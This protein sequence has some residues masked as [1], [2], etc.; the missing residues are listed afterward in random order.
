MADVRVDVE[1][2]TGP[3]EKD[4]ESLKGKLGKTF[5][6]MGKIAGGIFMA[7]VG[8]QI[9]SKGV[10]TLKT[11]IGLARDY[12]E[13]ISKSNTIFG[14]Q[15]SAVEQWA[16]SAATSFGQSKAE[17]L[18]AAASFG[19]M[20]T[21]LGM[22]S[23]TAKDMSIKMTELAS[24]FASF[25]NADITDVLQAQQAA[26]RGEYDALQKFVP[27][28]NAASVAQEAM[29][30]TGKKNTAELTAGEKAAAAYSLMIKG[31]GDATGDFERTSGS[32]ANQQR[33]MSAQWKDIQA[34][35][36]QALIPA[37]TALAVAINTQVI[38]AV[39]KFAQDFKRYYESDIKPA[40]ENIIAGWQKI[41]PVVLPILETMIKDFARV[42][43][44]F[45]LMVK[46]IVDLI[47]GDWNGAWNDVKQI[48]Q[49]AIDSLTEKLSILRSIGE[50]AFRGFQEGAAD[51]WAGIYGWIKGLP[52]QILTAIGDVTRLLW[53]KGMQI[54]QSLIDGMWSLKGK[55]PNPLDW[56]PGAGAI[57]GAIGD[58]GGF[59]RGVFD[60][61]GGGGGGGGSGASSGLAWDAQRQAYVQPWAVGSLGTANQANIN[62]YYGFG[63][64]PANPA[65]Q[66]II[67][68]IDGKEV[69][70]A[71]N[72]ANARAGV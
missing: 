66:P 36:G 17:A 70:R 45:A 51:V 14:E 21:Q 1:L 55:I 16:S 8:S 12:N 49:N 25:H 58:V 35:L 7:E 39:T 13:I 22:G 65:P 61:T 19:N 11:S 46:L 38:P 29:A 48:A 37:L 60:L 27:T 52:G 62:N 59:A 68:Q 63:Y 53:D 32:L 69:A 33:I 18:D 2:N 71:V 54:I 20:F 5:G 30:Q 26:F 24:D 6:D 47:S 23:E 28:I 42:A 34:Q 57:G 31:A 64:S 9:T 15:A 41:A 40:I 43:E 56:V 3:A 67:V 72:L 50:K 10:D 4:A 44:N